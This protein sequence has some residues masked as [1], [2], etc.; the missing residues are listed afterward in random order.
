MPIHELVE[1]IDDSRG[2]G[3]IER[4]KV[5]KYNIKDRKTEMMRSHLVLV[6]FEGNNLPVKLSLYG[7]VINIRVRPYIE[8]VRQCYNCL[9]YGHIGK[10]CKNPRI[11]FTCGYK[12]HGECDREVR[13]SNCE[14]KHRAN[15]KTCQVR[16]YNENIK[17]VM[18]EKN[19]SAFEAHKE[20]TG[21]KDIGG[22]RD[23][24]DHSIKGKVWDTPKEQDNENRNKLSRREENPWMNARRR[25][26]KETRN[27]TQER[28]GNEAARERTTDNSFRE[29]CN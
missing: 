7:D 19:I 12:Y 2:I 29:E 3:Q 15:D 9:R 8:P 16:L 26:E 6:T 18:A 28:E 5:R 24:H 22:T 17:E 4:M 11:C 25:K 10:V 14:G 21:N 13:Y 27:K 23:E 20:L 1:A